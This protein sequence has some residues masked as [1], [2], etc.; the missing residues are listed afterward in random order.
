MCQGQL[1]WG[2][3]KGCGGRE[4]VGGF[5]KVLIFVIVV[6]ANNTLQLTRT[7]SAAAVGNMIG[8]RKAAGKLCQGGQQ[9]RDSWLGRLGV[10]HVG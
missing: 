5:H 1:L 2:G 10:S 4:K 7:L 6:L 9:R 3:D 8:G